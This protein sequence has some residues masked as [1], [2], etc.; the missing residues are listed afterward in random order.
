[1]QDHKYDAR[2]DNEQ[3][4]QEIKIAILDDIH[5]LFLK[6]EPAWVL[7]DFQVVQHKMQESASDDDGCKERD[8]HAERKV[9]R[10]AL[11]HAG[12]KCISKDEQNQTRNEGGRV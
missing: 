4:D 10:K 12:A 5:I 6:P 1:M 11:N 7:A 3:R 8:D 2:D 9:D